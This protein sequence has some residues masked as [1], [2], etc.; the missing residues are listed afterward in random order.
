MN[1]LKYPRTITWHHQHIPN[2]RLRVL[3][4]NYSFYYANQVMYIVYEKW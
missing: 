2:H 1:K 3:L 4:F